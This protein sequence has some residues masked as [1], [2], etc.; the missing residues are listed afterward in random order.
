MQGLRLS[1]LK[2]RMSH[3]RYLPGHVSCIA[4]I[5]N[6]IK[7]I[8]NNRLILLYCLSMES[9]DKT[10]CLSIDLYAQYHIL[11]NV[12]VSQHVYNNGGHFE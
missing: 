12:R 3:P 1:I 4:E 2:L 10:I 7:A 11:Q 9:F 8:T 6:E 5:S